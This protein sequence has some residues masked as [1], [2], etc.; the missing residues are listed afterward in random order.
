MENIDSTTAEKVTNL[1]YLNQ[2]SKGNR[3]FECEMIKIFLAENPPEIKA[4]QKCIHERNFLLI[5][6]AA[7]KLKSTLP[8]VGLDK[9][10]G[11]DVTEMEMLA[12]SGSGIER[13][14]KIFFKVKEM[15]DKAYMELS[16]S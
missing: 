2:I 13:I 3:K 5:K 9:I 10:L 4:L 8:F 6:A 15:C 7:H 11:N 1:E 14:E 16:A 12:E